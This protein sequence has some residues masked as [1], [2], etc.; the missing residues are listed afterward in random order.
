[1]NSIFSFLFSESFFK[2]DN[3]N[4]TKIDCKD[5]NNGIIYINLPKINGEMIINNSVFSDNRAINGGSIFI[6]GLGIG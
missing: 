3:C 6:E 4:F 5:C 1:M 2:I